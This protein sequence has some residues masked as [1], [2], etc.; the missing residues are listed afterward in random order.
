[1]QRSLQD[2]SSGTSL[3]IAQFVQEWPKEE[4]VAYNRNI[5]VHLPTNSPPAVMRQLV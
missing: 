5:L 4:M 2:V 1:M 3:V